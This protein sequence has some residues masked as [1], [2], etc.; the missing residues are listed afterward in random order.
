MSDTPS[1][2]LHA[3]LRDVADAFR[4]QA[5]VAVPKETNVHLVWATVAAVNV[6]PPPTV[7]ITPGNVSG[8]DVWSH[9]SYEGWYNPTVGDNVLVMIDGTD[10]I[11]L[12]TMA[13]NGSPDDKTWAIVGV[14]VYRYPGWTA[15]VAGVIEKLWKVT[16][17]GSAAFE[18]FKNGSSV[19]GP[20]TANTTHALSTFSAITVAVG[21]YFELNVTVV[22]GTPDLSV[23]LVLDS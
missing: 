16:S 21:D 15:T 2:H 11:C 3:R 9:V 13:P 17:S 8:G 10:R 23:S 4:S 22:S 20:L 19:V 1:P 12:G 5:A 7:D 6:G 18:I 14:A